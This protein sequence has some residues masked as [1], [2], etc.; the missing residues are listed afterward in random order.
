MKIAIL[1]RNPKLYTT[2]RLYE[3]ALARQH[4]AFILDVRQAN[5]WA[6]FNSKVIRPGSLFQ[7]LIPRIGISATAAGLRV[8]RQLETTPIITTASSWGIAHSRDKWQSLLLLQSANLPTPQTVAITQPTQLAAALDELGQWPIIVKIPQG[9]Q[10]Q[11]VF[12]AQD[13]K[14]AQTLVNSLLKFRQKPVLLQEYIAEAQGRDLRFLVVGNRC[15]ATMQ[16][17]APHHDFRANVHRGASTLPF[18][19]DELT[20][21]LAT[22][23]AQI[24]RLAVAGVDIIQSTRGPLILEVNSSPG[25]EGIERTTQV[26]IAGQIIHFLEQQDARMNSD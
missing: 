18:T 7:A 8:I 17:I 25:L 4:T 21:H 26:D 19:P 6:G 22:K 14:A 23:A 10:G 15:L 2:K 3:S 11:G 12:L 16:R 24:H 9:T 20:A 1:S 13:K 5:R